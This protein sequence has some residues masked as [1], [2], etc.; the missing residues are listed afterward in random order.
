MMILEVPDIPPSPNVVKRKYRSPHAYKRLRDAWQVMLLA[1]IGPH[2]RASLRE[3]ARRA[4]RM[5][6]QIKLYHVGTYDDD[7]LAGSLKPVLDALVNI[8]FLA[9]DSPDKLN[10]L[11]PSQEK[12]T[13]KE[14]KTVV[15]IGVAE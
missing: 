3:L 9:G 2:H 5:C 12:C 13:K 14:L 15:R 11:P 7:N 6:V 4:G 8:G 1:S 10:L